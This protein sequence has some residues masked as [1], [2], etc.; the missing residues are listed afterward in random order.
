MGHDWATHRLSINALNG[1]YERTDLDYRES[2]KR[3]LVSDRLESQRYLSP[4]IKV[5]SN[6]GGFESANGHGGNR[7]RE[8][9]QTRC[10]ITESKLRTVDSLAHHMCRTFLSKGSLYL[11]V[12]P[13]VFSRE[14]DGR[15]REVGVPDHP[16]GVHPQNWSGTEQNRTVTSMVLKAKTKT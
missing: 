16:Q 5:T 4:R 12:D 10:E 11:T 6:R 3:P 7:T 1:E 15:G 14:V 8:I 13:Q 9:T 2:D